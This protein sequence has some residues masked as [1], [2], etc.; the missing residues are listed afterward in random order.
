[1]DNCLVVGN[2]INRCCGGMSWE[3]L[4]SKIARKY[5]APKNI[6]QSSTIAFEQLKCTVL[7]R[8]INLKKEDFAFCV[9]EE[10]DVLDR[11]KYSAIFSCFLS[12]PIENILTTNFDYSIERVLIADYQYEKYKGSIVRPQETKGSRIRHSQIKKRR[13][14]HIHGELGKKGTVC[15]G[16]VHYATNLSSLM[17]GLLDYSKDMD[18]FYLKDSVFDEELLSW[19]QFFFTKNIYIVGLGLYDCDM[20][21]WWLIAYRR[22]LILEGDTRITNKIVY[23]YI[24]EEKNQNFKECLESMGI[25]VREFEVESKKWQEAYILVSEDIKTCIGG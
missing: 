13:I 4:L 9:L 20:D 18:S 2:G 7:S 25:E 12:L 16:N 3:E 23:Y 5:F 15:L 6:M 10:L 21:L 11:D 17:N 22:Q 8:N 24:Y 14:F 1:M 19:G